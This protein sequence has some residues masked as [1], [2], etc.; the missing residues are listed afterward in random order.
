MKRLIRK[1]WF[2]RS[3]Q[4]LVIAVSALALADATVNH[5][6]AGTKRDAVELLKSGGHLVEATKFQVEMPPDEENFAMIPMLVALRA[7]NELQRDI[8]VKKPVGEKFA[9]LSLDATGKEIYLSRPGEPL[10]P[11]IFS[12]RMELKGTAVEMLNQFDQRHAEVLGALREGMR[13]R[14]AVM[15]ARVDFSKKEAYSTSIADLW[16]INRASIGL[17]LRT[18]LAIHAGRGDIALE[19]LLINRRLSDL[20]ISETGAVAQL[21]A[22]NIDRFSMPALFRGISAEVWDAASLEKL[23]QAWADR[24]PKDRIARTL[25]LEGVGMAIYCEHW[26]EDSSL[27]SSLIEESKGFFSR[28][29]SSAAPD[30]W[31]DMKSAEILRQTDASLEL[32]RSDRPLQSWWD[33]SMVSGK[34]DDWSGLH[35][36]EKSSFD[37]GLEGWIGKLCD[38]EPLAF[39]SL[40][41]AILK[42]GSKAM[43]DD[44][45][46]RLACL[47]GEY[48]IARGGYPE[49]LDAVGGDDI[50]DPLNGKPFVYRVENGAFRL[51]S[52]GPNGID[53]GGSREPADK[54]GSPEQLDWGW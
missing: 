40:V 14:W 30:A 13:R 35:P 39:D 21:F 34:P 5:R 16:K 15:P 18:E 28:L 50:V 47:I 20:T 10:D 48:K 38:L 9:L 37:P 1:K 12:E 42:R 7:E 4:G 52:V 17:S 41:S 22:W 29:R 46:V 2:R 11:K 49:A 23:R 26:K 24:D 44:S 33:N 3:L 32:V 53:D 19:S 36:R 8:R 25:N 6:A 51:Y 45:L 31:F 27:P 43:V 54:F